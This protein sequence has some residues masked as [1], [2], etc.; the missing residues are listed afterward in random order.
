MCHITPS[1]RRMRSITMSGSDSFMSPFPYQSA[2]ALLICS[3]YSELSGRL[4]EPRF[5]AIPCTENQSPLTATFGKRDICCI[6]VEL[7]CVTAKKL[8]RKNVA[9]TVLHHGSPSESTVAMDTRLSPL[10]FSRNSSL[11]DMIS[12]RRPRRCAGTLRIPRSTPR[13]LRWWRIRLRRSPHPALC[14]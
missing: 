8:S 4:M 14:A 9:L 12:L 2:K 10:Y 3:A 7:A 6:L 13:P 11:N 5:S 1:V